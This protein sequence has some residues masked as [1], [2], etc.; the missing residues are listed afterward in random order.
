MSARPYFRTTGM[1]DIVAAADALVARAE[2][3]LPVTV[4]RDGISVGDKTGFDVCTAGDGSIR[5]QIDTD[6]AGFNV[7]GLTDQ[8]AHELAAALVQIVAERSARQAMMRVR[9]AA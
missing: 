9:R 1:A 5:L 2:S 7:S 8:D 4:S 3:G 6:D